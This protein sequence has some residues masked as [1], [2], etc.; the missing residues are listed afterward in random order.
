MA[1]VTLGVC[2]PNVDDWNAIS[3]AHATCVSRRE[4]SIAGERV[5]VRGTNVPLTPALSPMQI[6]GGF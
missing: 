4:T 6:F 5:G 2:I 3:L 1:S